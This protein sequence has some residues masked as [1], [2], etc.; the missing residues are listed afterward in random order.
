MTWTAT[1]P[2]TTAWDDEGGRPV[3]TEDVYEDDVYVG[4]VWADT[5]G[6]TTAWSDA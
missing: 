5:T 4:T 6:P 1:T 3:Y 2:P